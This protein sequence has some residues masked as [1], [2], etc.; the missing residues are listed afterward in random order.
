MNRF[1][2]IAF[3]TSILAFLCISLILLINPATVLKDN[4]QIHYFCSY[5]MYSLPVHVVGCVLAESALRRA[6]GRELRIF[7]QLLYMAMLGLLFG[8]MLT[9]LLSG[10]EAPE[11]M[12][13]PSLVLMIIVGIISS[14][15]FYFIRKK[16][17]S[18]S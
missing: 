14:L 12:D 9:M 10:H 15:S 3:L 2:I 7:Q 4:G 6:Q 8:V 13:W 11:Q 17:Y 16:A 5:M 1:I 18:P